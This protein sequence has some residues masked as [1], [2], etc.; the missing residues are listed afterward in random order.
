[1]EGLDDLESICRAAVW[2]IDQ[3]LAEAAKVVKSIQ[4]SR[5]GRHK[6]MKQGLLFKVQTR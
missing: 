1:M 2:R 4:I 3:C 6:T 5:I